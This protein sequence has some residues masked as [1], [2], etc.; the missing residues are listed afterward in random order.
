[1]DTYRTFA[2]YEYNIVELIEEFKPKVAPRRTINGPE[3][4]AIS[5]HY[6]QSNVHL[7]LY[8]RI[9]GM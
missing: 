5:D 1:M 4:P 9:D 3:A 2:D 7:D 6:R 8:I